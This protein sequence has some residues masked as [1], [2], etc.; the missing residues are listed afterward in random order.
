M[1]HKK[2]TDTEKISFNI[3]VVDLGQIDLLVEQGFY[4]GR[5]DFIRAAIRNQLNT[6]AETVK[7]LVTRKTLTI[8]VQHFSRAALEGNRAKGEQIVV[9]AVGMLDIANDVTP[10]LALAVFKTINVHGV[11]RASEAVR[12]ALQDRTK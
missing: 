6:H 12:R 5:S 4:S 7:Q 10:E 11:L 8:G 1:E 9:N 3:S 2:M